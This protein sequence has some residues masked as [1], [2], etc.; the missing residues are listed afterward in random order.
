V[1]TPH[2]FAIFSKP[3]CLA[4]IAGDYARDFGVSGQ[5]M[6]PGGLLCVAYTFKQSSL[7]QNH[8]AEKIFMKK[9]LEIYRMRFGKEF[10]IAMKSQPRKESEKRKGLL[11]KQEPF[12]M[13]CFIGTKIF[14]HY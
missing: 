10:A 12:A 7:K 5:L 6:Y 9:D 11:L 3:R 13:N 14:R 8:I 4:L 2:S 1:L